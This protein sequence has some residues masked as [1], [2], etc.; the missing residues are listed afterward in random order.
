MSNNGMVYLVQ[1]YCNC[2][3]LITEWYTKFNTIATVMS[4][5]GMVYLL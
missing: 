1:H 5:N 4:N 2:K 3:C